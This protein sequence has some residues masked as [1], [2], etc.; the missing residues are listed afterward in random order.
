[1]FFALSFSSLRRPHRPMTTRGASSSIAFHVRHLVTVCRIMAHT[2]CATPAP[3]ICWTKAFRLRKSVITSVTARHDRRRSTPKVERKKLAQVADVELSSLTE[4]L[5][6]QTQ[7]ITADW[8]KE[9]LSS[10]QE[11][12]NFGLG[13]L[14]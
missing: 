6:T 1:M 9:R 10:L 5:R 2:V 12:S 3:P 4:Y 14:Q 11:V 8:A 13:G 7:P